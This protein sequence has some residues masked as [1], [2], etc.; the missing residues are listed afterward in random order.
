MLAMAQRMERE[1]GLGYRFH[2]CIVLVLLF[3]L[4]G[5]A[6]STFWFL[7]LLSLLVSP[8]MLSFAIIG[9]LGTDQAFG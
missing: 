9:R 7:S 1:R 6:L 2:C 5:F 3:H 4:Y 8:L